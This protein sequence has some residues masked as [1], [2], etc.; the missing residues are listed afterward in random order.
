MRSTMKNVAHDP[1]SQVPT[2]I[3]LEK[4]KTLEEK[5]FNPPQMLET[6]IPSVIEETP[7]EA[8]YTP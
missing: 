1:P 5:D 2:D 7:E 4:S 6:K 3:L 8:R